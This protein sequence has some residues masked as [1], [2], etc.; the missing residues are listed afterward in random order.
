MD[1]K[2]YRAFL[3]LLIIFKSICRHCIPSPIIVESLGFVEKVSNNILRNTSSS[4]ILSC[5][6]I[7]CFVWLVP[8]VL[9][10]CVESLAKSDFT[11]L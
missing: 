6:K 5:R 11:F 10:L 1:Y 3:Y 8:W 9:G 4:V 2:M 7:P